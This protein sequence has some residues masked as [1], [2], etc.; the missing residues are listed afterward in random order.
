MAR[1]RPAARKRN[2]KAEYKRRIAKGLAEGLSRAQARG[3]RRATEDPVKIFRIKEQVRRDKEKVFGRRIKLPTDAPRIEMNG[4]SV[5]DTASFEDFLRDK[6]KRE[7]R[8]E[9]TD[10]AAFINAMTELGLGANE[11]YTLWFS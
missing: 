5:P 8:Y 3:H 4:R 7:G 10:E 6:F 1:R 9:W 2:Y 11:A